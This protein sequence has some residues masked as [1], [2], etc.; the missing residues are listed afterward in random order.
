M[1][2]FKISKK[3][4]YWVRLVAGRF[5]SEG[6]IC[7]ASSLQVLKDMAYSKYW[8]PQYTRKLFPN[9]MIVVD[10]NGRNYCYNLTLTGKVRTSK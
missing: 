2:R 3:N 1:G 4:K 10:E 9:K 7:G 8:I 6:N 5:G